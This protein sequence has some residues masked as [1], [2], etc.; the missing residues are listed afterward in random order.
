MKLAVIALTM[1]MP[2]ARAPPPIAAMVSGF[3]SRADSSA[4]A[5]SDRVLQIRRQRQEPLGVHRLD[6]RLG[7]LPHELADLSED[8]RQHEDEEREREHGEGA[9]DDARSR[10]PVSAPRRSST[11][12]IGSSPSEMNSAS[13]M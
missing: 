4:R 1:P 10:R 5:G 2:T 3:A 11:R 6:H 8:R 7:E 9:E 12:T 13:T